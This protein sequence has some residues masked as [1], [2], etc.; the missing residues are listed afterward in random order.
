MKTNSDATGIE[1][2]RGARVLLFP[3]VVEPEKI[4]R[5]RQWPGKARLGRTRPRAGGDARPLNFEF[6][7]DFLFVASF[8]RPV[9]VPLCNSWNVYL[10]F[11]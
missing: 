9:C 3:R 6:K 7:V 8:E 1:R 2:K 11:R 10:N 5:R 4:K